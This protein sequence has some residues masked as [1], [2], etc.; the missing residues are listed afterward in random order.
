MSKFEAALRKLVYGAS[1]TDDGTIFEAVNGTLDRFE[2]LREDVAAIQSRLKQIEERLKTLEGLI[3]ADSK[4]AKVKAIIHYAENKR[5]GGQ[6]AVV[7][8]TK[9]IKG[10]T[11]VTR[12]YAYDIVDE[13][14]EDFPFLVNRDNLDQYG[15]LELDTDA[16]DKGIAVVFEQVPDDRDSLNKFN[17]ET[18]A[19]GGEA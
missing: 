13:W 15:Q 19:E 4:V 9:E 11:G 8:D 3:H 16:R 2:T 1:E 5:E 6:D 7:L 10:A 12:R 18:A 17:N 14:P